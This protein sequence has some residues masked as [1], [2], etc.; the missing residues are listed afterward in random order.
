MALE[1]TDNNV[2]EIMAKGLPVVIDFGAEWCGPCKVVSPII[3]ELASEYQ[4]QVIIGKCDVDENTEL[5]A[6]Y[7]IRNIP[8]ILF[9]E[10]GNVVDKLVSAVPKDKIEAK[11]KALL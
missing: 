1:I 11:I 10:N 6:R 7:N 9:I 2:D 3:D 8:T 5:A 4:D